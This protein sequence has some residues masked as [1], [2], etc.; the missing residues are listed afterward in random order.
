MNF[1]I[2]NDH[3][4]HGSFPKIHPFWQPDLSL[5]E[6]WDPKSRSFPNIEMRQVCKAIPYIQNQIQNENLFETNFSKAVTGK[7]SCTPI[8]LLHL[9]FNL[10][11]IPLK[12]GSFIVFCQEAIFDDIRRGDLF[13]GQHNREVLAQLHTPYRLI[14]AVDQWSGMVG[15][16]VPHCWKL[17]YWIF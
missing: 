9:C 6:Y 4:P 14:N 2:E 7:I 11:T 12:R 3:P 8:F 17:N 16:H 1:W 5:I 10:P 15:W 13:A